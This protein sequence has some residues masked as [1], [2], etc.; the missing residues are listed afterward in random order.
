M[1]PERYK[2]IQSLLESALERDAN[3]RNAFLA[4]ACAGDEALRQQVESLIISHERAASSLE[5]PVAEFAAPLNSHQPKLTTGESFGSYRVV[6]QLGSGGMGEVYLAEDSRL[7]RKVALKVLRS[8]FTKDTDRLRRFEQEACAV[9]ALNHPN[10][11]TIHEISDVGPVHFMVTEF[12]DGETLRKMLTRGPMR[13]VDLLPVGVQAASALAAAHESGIVHRDIKPENIMV[14]RDGYVKV[15]DFGIAKLSE[16]SQT[17]TADLDALTKMKT[18]PGVLL[19]TVSYMSPEQARGEDVDAR[20]DVWSLGVVLYEM[21]TGRVPFSGATISHVLVSI[22]DQQLP[23]LGLPT[24]ESAVEFERIVTKALAKDRAERYQT[25]KDL[26]DDLKSLQQELEFQSKLERSTAAP[27]V[28]EPDPAAS[29]EQC[30]N[31]LP[32]QV[33][34]LIGRKAEIVAVGKQLRREDLRLLTLT[35][36]GG[37]GKTSLAVAVAADLLHEFKDGVFLVSLAAIRDSTLVPSTVAQ[38]LGVK[39]AGETSLLDRLKDFLRVREM[40]LVIDNFEQVVEAATVVGELLNSSPKLK[41]LITSREP[42][43]ITG[44]HEF[45]VPTLSVPALDRSQPFETWARYPAVELFVE[46]AAAVKPEFEFTSDNAP[47]IVEI[48]SR[49]DGLPL[50]IE[51][52]AARVKVLPPRALLA[53]LDSRL[54]VLMGGARDLPSRQQTMRGAIAWSYDLL[55]EEEKRLF[56]RLSVFVGGCQLESIDAVCNHNGDLRIEVLEGVASL[57]NKSLLQQREIVNGEARFTMLETITEF[58]LHELLSSGELKDLSTHHAE[59]FLKL[60]ENNESELIGPQQEQWLDKFE[61]EHANFRAALLWSEQN[62]ATEIGLKLATSLWRFWEMRG[63]LSEGR[64]RLAKLL[65]LDGAQFADVRLKALY[66]AGIL[67]DAQCDYSSARRLFDE[68]LKLHQK[69]GD[70]WGVANSIN[71]LGIIALRD[72]DYVT[73]RALYEESLNLWQELGNER[74]VALALSNLGNVAD[75]LGDY[76]EAHNFYQQSLQV[77]KGLHDQR[78]VALSLSHLGTVAKHR[79]DHDAAR[80]FFDQSL[81][82]LIEIGDKRGVADLFGD[83]GNMAEEQ[84]NYDQARHFYEESMVIFSG[85]GDVRGIARV[86]EATA[87]MAANRGRLERA[88]RLAGAASKLRAE[89]DAPRSPD[90]ESKMQQTLI[91]IRQGLRDPTGDISWQEGQAMSAENAIQYA[92]AADTV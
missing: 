18:T 40:L 47:A 22:Q 36:P 26:L 91:T 21:V 53:R 8:D 58:A 44:E 83:M 15:L 39:E 57:V 3:E 64:E 38:I 32:S 14:R 30:P 59:Y 31:N 51:L 81:K 65:A 88:L 11:L 82:I 28:E 45:A 74:A 89:Y 50:A 72:R 61:I 66:A 24:T 19:G 84:G 4:E 12:I 52:A 6:A 13:V 29:S 70:N 76:A 20:A 63:Y 48:C 85:L 69:L 92:L 87:Q 60:A 27:V 68:K 90:E 71:N 41:I 62:S 67:A 78:G 54:K 35:G 7:K 9:S 2:R 56:R 79:G 55:D 23:A 25:A 73:A 77:F 1:N 37:T 86:M 17:T 34:Q 16:K 75:M 80:H 46:R 43:R 5:S 10:I 42:L 33:T 49:L